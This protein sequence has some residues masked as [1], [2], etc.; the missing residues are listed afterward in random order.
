MSVSLVVFSS[1]ADI[2]ISFTDF[3]SIRKIPMK[4]RAY[5][6]DA[7]SAITPQDDGEHLE[8]SQVQVFL[9]RIRSKLLTDRAIHDQASLP[10]TFILF[11]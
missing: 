10:L 4:E 3:L 11:N 6:T 2:K 1:L 8:D 9:D 5:L 7:H